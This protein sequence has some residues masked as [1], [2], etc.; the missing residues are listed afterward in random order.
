MKSKTCSPLIVAALFLASCGPPP[1]EEPER[2]AAERILEAP[3]LEPMLGLRLRQLVAHP[4]F[5][6]TSTVAVH[7]FTEGDALLHPDFPVKRRRVSEHHH[8]VRV[9]PT[10]LEKLRAIEGVVSVRA[11][12]VAGGQLNLSGPDVGADVANLSWTGTNAIVGIVDSGLDLSKPD[13]E[14]GSGNTRV[15]SLWDATGTDPSLPPPSSQ[16]VGYECDADTIDDDLCPHQDVNGHG[17][18]VAGIAAGNGASNGN[19]VGVAPDADLVIV[20]AREEP[21]GGFSFDLVADGIDY[22]RETA[23][24]LGRPYVVN[25]SLGS[26]S[27]PHDGC[28][29]DDLMFESLVV[30]DGVPIVAASGNSGGANGHLA[31]DFAPGDAESFEVIVGG[32]A[33][34]VS[35]DFWYSPG[36]RISARV[37]DPLGICTGDPLLPSEPNV[38]IALSDDQV[39]IGS[40]LGLASCSPA[41]KNLIQ[42]IL[43]ANSQYL[44]S[45]TWAIELAAYE[46]TLPD[47]GVVHGWSSSPGSAIFVAGDTDTS[48]AVPASAPSVIAVGSYST[49]DPVDL[50]YPECWGGL[51][52]DFLMPSPD[53]PGCDV[54]GSIGDLS[55]FSSKGPLIGPAAPDKPDLAGP[56]EWIRSVAGD[57][58][59]PDVVYKSG[60]SMAAPH[61]TG[62]I[63][64]MLDKNP[65]R[66][67]LQLATVLRVSADDAPID[68]AVRTD[69]WGHGKLDVVAALDLTPASSADPDHL[70]CNLSPNELLAGGSGQAGLTVQIVDA[71]GFVVDSDADV[72]VALVS[73]GSSATFVGPSS[74]AAV[75][76]VA[77]FSLEATSTAGTVTLEA[78]TSDPT[79]GACQS[80]LEV[81]ASGGPTTVCGTID[82]DTTWALA[83]SPYQL[84]CDVT[85]AAGRTLTI[86]PGVA[87]QPNTSADLTINGTLWAVGT[88]ANPIVFASTTQ[89]SSTWGGVRFTDDA[90]AE[91]SRLEHVTFRYGGRTSAAMDFPLLIHPYSIPA[92]SD[93][94]FEDNRRN[95]PLIQG[96][97]F[98]SDIVFDAPGVT[99]L[100]E[101]DMT[102]Q[103]SATLTL[104]E[105]T[106]LKL[107][108]SVDIIVEG[109]FL[110]QGTAAAP[111]VVT[112]YRDDA[113][114]GDANGDG[115]SSGVSGDWGG[116]AFRSSSN[117]ARTALEHV[118]LHFGGKDSAAEDY[119][120]RMTGHAQP[121]MSQ[122]QLISCEPNAVGL[123]GGTY[124]DSFEL[125]ALDGLAYWPTG[126]ITVTE[127]STLTLHPGATFKMSGA[128]DFV[129]EGA[130]D[131]V[132][133]P[134]DPIVFTSYRD[135][136]ILGDSNANGA[137]TGVTN[138]WGGIAFR[139]TANDS[140]MSWVELHYGGANSAAEDYPISIALPA[141]PNL[142]HVVFDDCSP[143]AIGLWGGTITGDRLIRR[144]DGLPYW[145]TSDLI[146]ASS[147]T[148]TI[149]PGAHFKASGSTDIQVNG[150]LVAEAASDPIVFTSYRD[151]SRWGDTNNDGA[152]SGVSA[153]WGG[154]EFYSTS[155]GALTVLDGVEVW[156]G[157]QDSQTRDWGL[158]FSG[159]DP[160]VQN[161]VVGNTD[162]GVFATAGAAPDL[163]GGAR[164][165]VGN[166]SF[167]GFVPSSSDPAVRN[168][169]T[170]DLYALNNAWGVADANIPAVIWDQADDSSRGAVLYGAAWTVCTP[171]AQEACG[172]ATGEC[173][174]GNRTCDAY[175]QWGA[176]VGEIVGSE[177]VCDGLDNDCDGSVDET[178]ARACGS[179]VGECEDGTQTCDLG[180]W[181]V[182]TGG[183]APAAEACDALDNDCDGA[184]DEDLIEAC[185]S[186]VGECDLGERTCFAGTWSA[187]AGQTGPSGEICDS[188]DNDCDGS[189]DEA[190]TC[191]AGPTTKCGTLG[192][193]QTWNLAGSPYQLTC[194]VTVPAGLTLTIDPGVTVVANQS[195]DLS[196][197]GALWAEG[198]PAQPIVFEGDLA[199]P[200]RWGGIYFDDTA[201]DAGSRLAHVTLR[202]GGRTSA[203]L[204]HVLL[205]DARANPSLEALTFEDNRYNGIGVQGGTYTAGISLDTPGIPYY[206]TSD[207]TIGSAAVLTIV[208]GAIVKLLGAG[209]ITIQ[210]GLMATGTESEPILLT[211][212]E[213][214]VAGG[215]TNG[216]GPTVGQANDWG[217]IYFRDTTID[218]SSILEHVEIRYA[219]AD[220][221]AHDYPIRIDGY[222]NPTF[223]DVTITESSPNA[224]GLDTGTYSSSF[225]LGPMDGLSYWINGDIT[226]G[227]AA[228]LTI[229]PGT[230]LKMGGAVDINVEG[231]L[232]AVGTG[233]EPIVLTAQADD[234]I[235]GDSGGD[236]PSVGYPSAW[237]GI[238]FTSSSSDLS[239]LQYAELRFGGADSA[240]VDFPIRLVASVNPTIG[241]ITFVDSEPNAIGL[242]AG[243]YAS[244]VFIGASDGLTHEL[245]GDLQILQSAILTIEA[246]ALLKMNGSEDLIIHGD[247]IADG[248]AAP[249]VLTSYRDDTHG[250][251]SNNNG[252]SIGAADDWGG[253]QFEPTSDGSVSLLRGVEIYYG[254]QDSQAVD[255]ALSFAGADPLVENCVVGHSNPGV[256]IFNDGS[257][258]LGGGARGSSGG[259]DFLGFSASRLAISNF[260]EAD[261]L[262]RYNYWETD[263]DA[264]IEDKVYHQF[265]DSTRGLVVWDGFLECVPPMVQAC[266]SD[267]GECVSGTQSCELTGY[268]GA[269]DDVEPVDEVCDGLDNNCDGSVPGDEVDAD[270]DGYLVCAGDCDDSDVNRNPAAAEACNGID[271]DCDGLVPADEA[272]SDSDGVRVCAGDCDDGLAS[273]WPGAPELC[274]GVD[275]DCDASVPADEA[276]ADGDPQRICAGDCDDADASTW[277]GAPELCDGEDNDCD[278]SVPAS[279]ADDDA[280]SVRVCAGDCDDTDPT[281]WPA[282]TEACDGI[283]NDCDGAIPADEADDDADGQRICAGDCNDGSATIFDG[284]PELCDGW[285]DDCDGFLGALEADADADTFFTCTYVA[286][287]G[288]PTFAGDDCED[289][290]PA[291]FPGAPEV[292]DGVDNDCDGT[293]ADEGL[294]ED[295]DGINTCTD[296]DDGDAN[297]YP[298]APEIC[299]G[300]DDDCDGTIPADE[301]DPDADGWIECVLDPAALARPAI[302]GGDDCGPAVAT[303]FPGAPEACNGLDDDCDGA[304]PADEADPDA[305]GWMACEGDC[306][307]AAAATYPTAP[308]VCDGADNDCNAAVPTDELDA[309]ADG[310]SPCEGDCNDGDANVGPSAPEVCNGVDDDCDGALP[311]DEADDDADGARICDGDCDDDDASV[312]PASIELCNG[313]DDD[314]DGV[315]P[316]DEA[317]GDADGIMA[318]AGDCDDALATVFPA[319]PEL[320]DGLDNDCDSAVS[321]DE[322]DDDA[323]GYRVCEG[324][325]DDAEASV[326]PAAAEVCDGLDNDCDSVIPTDEQDG[327]AD[328]QSPCAGDCDDADA[329]VRLGAPELCDG[330]D[331]DCSGSPDFDPAGEADADA[332]GS[333]SCADC[334][335]ADPA[336]TPSAPE[337]CDGADNDCDGLPNADTDGEVDAD[338]DGSL[339]CEDCDDAD[340]TSYPAGVELCDGLDNDCD[341]APSAD[342]GGEADADADGSLSCEDCDDN[343]GANFPANVEIC[344]GQDNDCD[345][346]AEN[347]TDEDGD[348]QT[349]CDGDCDDQDPLVWEGAPE[350][351]SGL[352]EDCNG[353]PDADFAGEVDEDAD[354]S[355]SCEDCDDSNDARFPANPEVCDGV[356]NDCSGDPD[357]DPDGEVDADADGSLSCE[358]CDDADGANSPMGVEVCDGA[359]NDCDG[360]P[361]ADPDGEVDADADGS[362]S[363]EDCD[364]DDAATF[365]GNAEFCD[366]ADTDCDPSTNFGDALET[367]DD[368]DGFLSCDDCDDSD[369]VRFPGNAEICDG[370]DN[371]CD[372][373]TNDVGDIDGDGASICD[374]DCDDDDPA[375]HPA[376]EEVCNGIDDDCD[377][378]TDELADE[379]GDGD[380]L[381]DGD[382]DDDDPD[383]SASLPELC[384][385]IDNDCDG[386]LPDDE[387]DGDAD[388]QTPCEGDCDDDEPTSWD[389]APELCD[390]LDNDCDGTGADELFDGDGDGSSACQGDCDDTNAD[391]FDGAPEICDG[392]DDDCDAVLPADEGD[393]DGDGALDCADCDAADPES[394]PGAP[395]LCDGIDNDCDGALPDDELDGD[396]DGVL[397]CADCDDEDETAFPGADELCD[398]VDN[399]CDGALPGDEG[400]SDGDGALACDDCDDADEMSFP[401]ADE[402]CD[403]IDNDCDGALPEDEADGDGDGA[404]ACAD[405]DDEDATATPDAD[406]V[407]DGIDNDCDGALPDDE[408]DADADGWLACDGDCDDEAD[409]ANPDVD[410]ESGDTC[411]DDLDNDCDGDVDLNDA[412]CEPEPASE[413]TDC[414]CAAGSSGA[415]G[416]LA[417]LLLVLGR[418][419]RRARTA[420]RPTVAVTTART[421]S[422]WT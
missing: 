403:G 313:V 85:L 215:D 225:T 312:G 352:D 66:T 357:A 21:N 237:G 228:T 178:L 88:A 234:S 295:G 175:G 377:P 127:T 242:V 250:G 280:D 359:D 292:C 389:G 395:E 107:G 375:V 29:A 198:T 227:P 103:S 368:A 104:V 152:S 267:V 272:D 114:W 402:L 340:E 167:V 108:S 310:S 371:D 184:A 115:P 259:N 308:E 40:V 319:A 153:D 422:S 80:T 226:V 146:V 172:V 25:L 246:G 73:G 323:D 36:D 125:W 278:G 407:C 263:D 183:T 120:I 257:P 49:N 206:L 191:P 91:N 147:A 89:V 405:C 190:I 253:V 348:G 151:D 111:I 181:G 303:I 112:S 35:F 4:D 350:L 327:D 6:D 301:E 354:G 336:N 38:N 136:T 364:D 102:I 342:P 46:A 293:T 19:L 78:T 382:C 16:T 163:G 43:S 201:N 101:A 401:G 211:S 418:G 276:N 317:D 386:L 229:Q 7:V 165:S 325:C 1:A 282:A 416:S 77:S 72:D 22:I 188:L 214:D 294:D 13:F 269:C 273:V 86:E 14:D 169:T 353:T 217:G 95:A 162:G 12:G 133:T 378:S 63:A 288:N 41:T 122:V 58:W 79:L 231:R 110:A 154:L 346:V 141:A 408:A 296:C 180:S 274:D 82:A 87:V 345:G 307:D 96:G 326:N 335:D 192:S 239:N 332:D 75:A 421:G 420:R 76:G 32:Q 56:G 309:D 252:G 298:G 194:D 138:D 247:L 409:A 379:D 45:G 148:L 106:Q 221:A 381:C 262:A 361:D 411:D 316:A 30:D 207:L 185:G 39:V 299:D 238:Y 400:D 44:T 374:G 57:G 271:D 197:Y 203:A 124:S 28:S 116:I 258:D 5:D 324:D 390:G 20:D 24:A 119:P 321:A 331:N 330:L 204:D 286:S 275:N 52:P 213:D 260:S 279:E 74:S 218:A 176:C 283:D 208:P 26:V 18:H 373:G 3:R 174:T 142:D 351:C 54:D 349:V 254:G 202:H 356:D 179:D 168:D 277:D 15:I 134:A 17:T 284:A 412:D 369:P 186:D 34:Q 365:P 98:G 60:T 306:D 251:D 157:G 243:T 329:L 255:A 302:F 65:N 93:L 113:H 396:A 344:D 170:E 61:V 99:L 156:Y 62:A 210:G 264:V 414:G 150:N 171:S 173:S 318:C 393:G 97:T 362:L 132:G 343:D 182:C 137:S 256:L 370:I 397:A 355:L 222:A 84:T 241:D 33:T 199:Y 90:N 8:V 42:I 235:G 245:V 394:W 139:N 135:D 149:E 404:L 128:T 161:C 320:C 224:V 372:P 145:I 83:G 155:D 158:Y 338:A 209:D 304:L 315:L 341:G 230:W 196:V 109:G 159:T 289:A 383:T 140:T 143:N 334:D 160:K 366:G 94:L 219:G 129:I 399:D 376:A 305:D 297:V 50:L 130:L 233:P 360:A 314:C 232:D 53:G 117:P 189:A 126:D 406:E 266:G 268:W 68:P 123:T 131:A 193:S 31:H 48:L 205:L 71:S 413:D 328:G 322:A 392:L 387:Q 67:P 9:V 290:D 244:D 177:E 144:N 10:A 337:L 64:L 285:D 195:T 47:G 415:T 367:D 23:E 240:A 363:C 347:V 419:R 384:D 187:C 385:A 270:G 2:A 92:M 200:S 59:G 100:M 249:I 223:S 417:L 70:V 37:C 300:A 261:V 398:G 105:D 291:T 11:V 248:T 311:P 81:L 27:G 333:L 391:V 118:E 220:S 69:A 287:G 358:D 339:S 216:D 164:G 281:A 121:S 265:D 410:S 51:T 166:N 380:S 388:G 55:T 236:G 212:F